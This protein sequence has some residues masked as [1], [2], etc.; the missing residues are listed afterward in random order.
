MT[1]A[2]VVFSGGLD[3]TTL[4]Y[5]LLAEGYELKAL[6]VDYG[7][8]HR[9]RE[10]AA[11]ETICRRLGVERRVVDLRSLVELLGQNS[12]SDPSVAVPDG[13][14]ESGTMQVTTVPN[15]NMVLISVALAWAVSLKYG[16][17]AYGAHGGVYTNYPDCRP[18]FAAAL[19]HAAALCDWEPVRVLAPFVHWDKGDIVK[20][21]VELAVPFELTWSCYKGGDRH[22]G[23]CGTCNDRKEAFRKHGLSDPLAYEA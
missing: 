14:Y 19:D 4:L 12:L 23:S 3:S 17:V 11:A 9:G 15:R 7:Q 5:H 8:R 10:L 2:V 21:G 22:C 1:K 20:R 16:A 6:S 13:K 18:E